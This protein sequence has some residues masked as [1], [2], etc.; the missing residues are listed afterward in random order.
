MKF[1][2]CD[3]RRK[4]RGRGEGLSVHLTGFCSARVNCALVLGETNR[5]TSV[6]APAELVSIK[7]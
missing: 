7:T 6:K 3:C 4:E 5:G 1:T 2:S